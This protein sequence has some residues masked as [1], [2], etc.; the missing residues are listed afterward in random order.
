MTSGVLCGEWPSDR[1]VPTSH[2]VSACGVAALSSEARLDSTFYTQLLPY[3]QIGVTGYVYGFQ[4]CLGGVIEDQIRIQIWRY[5]YNVNFWLK[6][7]FGGNEI[8][9]TCLLF[10]TRCSVMFARHLFRPVAC[11]TEACYQLIGDLPIDR[12]GDLSVTKY[13]QKPIRTE[14]TE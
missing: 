14:Q 10:I 2:D 9:Y 5:M 3:T 6:G 11:S 12:T 7:D 8:N 4:V 1:R 13:L